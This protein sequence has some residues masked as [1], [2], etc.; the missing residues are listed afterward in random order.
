MR[1]KPLSEK[2]K[3]K[4]LKI[5]KLSLDVNSTRKN[6]VFINFSGHIN[7]LS[8]EFYTTGW[9]YKAQDFFRSDVDLDS[10][11]ESLKELDK[12]IRKFEDIKN[13]E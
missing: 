6:T 9:E 13:G 4:I 2:Q 1:G 5:T 12:I 11:R 7:Q 8:V 10:K 3:L